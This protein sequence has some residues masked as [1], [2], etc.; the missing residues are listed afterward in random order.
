M[1]SE[2]LNKLPKAA[3]K[4]VIEAEARIAEI[5]LEIAEIHAKIAELDKI[6]RIKL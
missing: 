5:D 4:R 2:T 6:R 3:R 1:N